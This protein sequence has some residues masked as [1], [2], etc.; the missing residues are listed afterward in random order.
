[1]TQS[2]LRCRSVANPISSVPAFQ[3]LLKKNP[4]AAKKWLAQVTAHSDGLLPEKQLAALKKLTALSQDKFARSAK[5]PALEAL[6]TAAA[7][8]SDD[9]PADL[10]IIH[11]KLAVDRGT[12]VVAGEQ[13][14]REWPDLKLTLTTDGG[15][16]FFLESDHNA[17]T[18]IYQFVPGTDVMA[19]AGQDV[20]LRGFIDKAGKAVRVT[21]FAPGRMKD[22]VTGRVTLQGADVFIRARGRGLVKV[23]DPKLK[24]ELAAHNNL[25]VIL[26]GPTTEKKHA[27]GSV[28]RVFEGAPKEYWMLV[29]FTEAPAVGADGKLRGP[30]QA[31]TSQTSTTVEL[32][33]DEA[34]HIEIND[35]MYVLGRFHGTQVKA[36]KAT[37]SAGTPWSTA[38]TQRGAA[39]KS[40]IEFIEPPTL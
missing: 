21:E 31:A 40:V 20:S 16:K 23:S 5:G 13:G 11:G 30:I 15:K 4:A 3:S 39:M 26:E 22:F 1:M 38:T 18:D 29:R 36:S 24:A 9:P 2:A 34:K 6:F 27:D 10:P 35:R 25:G 8:T 17:R 14:Y 37:P 19:F 33:A 7:I 28:T 12:R 32:T